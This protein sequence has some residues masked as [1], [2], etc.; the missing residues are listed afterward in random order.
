MTIPHERPILFTPYHLPLI[1]NLE[2]GAW[3]AKPID[4]EQA[5]KWQTLRL[6]GLEEVNRTPD[7]WILKDFGSADGKM[8]A[9]FT[10]KN[11]GSALT[12]ACPYGVLG[13]R[14][15]VKEA[16]LARLAGESILYRAD[17]DP[18][19]AAGIG[20]MYGGWKSARFMPKR[21]ARFWLELTDVSLERLQEIAVEDIVAEGLRS[22]LR[23]PEACMDLR[24]QWQSRWDAINAKAGL[25]HAENPWVWA[26][27]YKRVA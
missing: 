22:T 1:R 2:V 26:L 12:C 17:L 3:P 9:V 10:H 18:V 11:T 20:A 4:Q 14:L 6:A 16:Y 25:G 7:L 13:D 24:L 21:V 8:R 15:Y 27:S 19:E 5:W 23:E